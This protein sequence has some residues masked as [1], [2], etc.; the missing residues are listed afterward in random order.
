[1]EHYWQDSMRTVYNK[2][3]L[4]MSEVPDGSIQCV[5]TSPPYWRLR[6]YTGEQ[7]LIWGGSNH[8][9]HEWTIAIPDSIERP[10]YRRDKKAGVNTQIA[11]HERIVKELEPNVFSHETIKEHQVRRILYSYF[12]LLNEWRNNDNTE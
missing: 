11:N 12:L 5:V 8:H 6:K 9:E 7:D 2:S 4:D 1:M 3:C 10:S